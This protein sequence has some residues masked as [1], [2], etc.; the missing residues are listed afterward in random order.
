MFSEYEIKYLVENGMTL[1]SVS[2]H[3]ENSLRDILIVDK[4]IE[5][6]THTYYNIYKDKFYDG[7]IFRTIRNNFDGEYKINIEKPRT[8][9][10]D[11]SKYKFEMGIEDKDITK[12]EFEQIPKKL[13]M[14]M[15]LKDTSRINIIKTYEQESIIYETPNYIIYLDEIE[16]IVEIKIEFKKS[17]SGAINEQE[18]YR[19]FRLGNLKVSKTFS[20]KFEKHCLKEIYRYISIGNSLSYYKV[21]DDKKN[22]LVL[23]DII[24]TIYYNGII[25]PTHVTEI[26]VRAIKESKL[27]KDVESDWSKIRFVNDLKTSYRLKD[28]LSEDL[29]VFFNS[30][31]EE[32]IEE[33]H[34]KRR[35]LG[36]VNLERSVGAQ[37]I[38]SIRKH[39]DCLAT[40]TRAINLGILIEKDGVITRYNGIN[41]DKYSSLFNGDIFEI[42]KELLK[43]PDA[44]EL[45]E[46]S[47]E[48]KEK[49]K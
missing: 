20:N 23:I 14:S 35:E 25:M 4:N 29:K 18:I 39:S 15:T 10:E 27:I 33:L 3:I 44:I 6:T 19:T 37:T 49:I 16:G 12:E 24:P 7:H 40:I 48:E 28:F 31:P 21:I 8:V 5:S 43:D 17:S 47:I 2:S 45:L 41:K 26:I 30:S 13:R 42:V 36:S 34:T 22:D 1:K 9:R 38:V 11:P 32:F 46:M